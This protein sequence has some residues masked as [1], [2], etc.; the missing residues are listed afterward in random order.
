MRGGN[1]L[2]DIIGLFLKSF[3]N[4]AS[5]LKHPS[6]EITNDYS[7]AFYQYILAGIM[8]EPSNIRAGKFNRALLHCFGKPYMRHPYDTIYPFCMSYS[9][10]ETRSQTCMAKQI[11][12]RLTSRMFRSQMIDALVLI[13]D[14]FLD[15]LFHNHHRKFIRKTP[16]V[17][18]IAH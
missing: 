3:N 13:P 12:L 11:M 17:R 6:V 5:V 4:G 18:T 8:L 14:L 1:L 7:P 16:G 10:A 2:N 9:R 15:S